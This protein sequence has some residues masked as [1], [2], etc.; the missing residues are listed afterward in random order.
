M[1]SIIEIKKVT[2]YFG[3]ITALSNLSFDMQEHSITAVIGPNGA[4]KTTLFN[5]ISGLYRPDAGSIFFKGKCTDTLRAF[6]VPYL[7]IARTFQNLRVFTN[8]NVLENVMTGRYTRSAAGFFTC[9]CNL[10]RYRK[11]EKD[12]R[13]KALYWLSFMNIENLWNKKVHE[14]PFEA[15]RLVEIT[16]ALASE[17]ELILMDEPAAGLNITET[18]NLA[19]AIYKIRELGVSIL[20]VEHDMDLVMEVSEK[21]IVLNFGEKIAEGSPRDIQNDSK[22]ISVYLGRELS[23]VF[24]QTEK[25]KS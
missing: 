16:R 19:D 6:E 22:V 9:A 2:K 24:S 17:P 1:N 12:I 5:L 7:G 15:Q 10:R 11:E 14:I 4:G 13:E 21:I 3:G 20:I 23:A 25:E 8:M 18:K